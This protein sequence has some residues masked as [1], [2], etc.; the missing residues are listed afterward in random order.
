VDNPGTDQIAVQSLVD[1]YGVQAFLSGHDHLYSMSEYKDVKYMLA[2]SG[3]PKLRA[4]C[5]NK[6]YLPWNRIENL[7]IFFIKIE[8][9]L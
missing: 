4:D 2:G 1:E 8:K 9:A 6:Y 7:P 3:T 5:L